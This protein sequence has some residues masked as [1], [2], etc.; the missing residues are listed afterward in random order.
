MHSHIIYDKEEVFIL[1]NGTVEGIAIAQVVGCH[2]PELNLTFKGGL[3]LLKN[4]PVLEKSDNFHIVLGASKPSLIIIGH[5]EDR[6]DLCRTVAHSQS[7]VTAN[8]TPLAASARTE[9]NEIY[10]Y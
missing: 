9:D 10:L 2:F 6:L 3:T 7:A 5:N 4:W 8:N 1:Y